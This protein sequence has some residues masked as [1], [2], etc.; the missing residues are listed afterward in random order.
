MEPA[1]VEPTVGDYQSALSKAN[2]CSTRHKKRKDVA[3]AKKLKAKVK[4]EERKRKQREAEALGNDAPPKQVPNTL[5][6]L[7]EPDSTSVEEHPPED[8]ELDEFSSY[9]AKSYVPKVLIT[10]SA[11][12][13]LKTRLFLKELER[14]IP[15]S[16]VFHRRQAK[17]KNIV[18]QA[19]D[20][21]LR[22]SSSSTKTERSQHAH[23]P[24][25]GRTHLF[26]SI[27]QCQVDQAYQTGLEGNDC[28]PPEVLWSNFRTRLGVGIGRM[29]ASLFHYQPEF[30]GRRIVTFHNQRDYIFFRHHRYEFKK[31]GT[32][33]AL[34]E[35]GPRFTLKLRSVQKGTFESKTGEYQWIITNKRHRMEDSRRRFHL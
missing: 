35:L 33:A 26:L 4:K 29:F 22:I 14:V 3:K 25:T 2:R 20:M 17:I 19:K 12:P 7:R 27:E 10:S 30:K 1:P 34:R 28:S 23:H 13:N 15:N 21:N 24:L 31:N 16:I 32:K 9:F 18:R 11:N 8:V 5:E 6:T